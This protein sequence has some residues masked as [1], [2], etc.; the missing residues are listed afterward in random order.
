MNA[1]A[2]AWANAY[3]ANLIPRVDS[4][5]RRDG[6]NAQ[7]RYDVWLQIRM[8]ELRLL[9]APELCLNLLLGAKVE[10][11]V[12]NKLTVTYK[13]PQLERSGV[14]DLSGLAGVCA[15]DAVEVCP[16]VY[17]RGLVTV[18]VPRY[19]GETLSYRLEPISEYDANGF[20]MDAPVIGEAYRPHAD[21]AAVI[22][23]KRLDR[24]AFG[25]LPADEIQRAKDKNAQPFAHL[26]DG[27]GIDSLEHLKAIQAPTWLPRK[28]EAIDVKLPKTE[29]PPRSS[30]AA[31]CTRKATPS[32][33][34]RACRSTRR[35]S[36]TSTRR[37]ACARSWARRGR[38]RCSH[39][40]RS[41]TRRACPRRSSPLRRSDS[42]AGKSRLRADT[43]AR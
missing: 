39:C 26:N 23:A 27:R 30:C 43:C 25:D 20:R 24:T 11:K 29:A 40:W 17:G 8:E 35:R 3:N 15:G 7:T 1:A 33:C 5:L 42:R 21:T 37:C 38:R 34:P 16:M 4:R 2:F 36:A 31:I 22:A 9:P 19:D 18:R 12:S 14:Y 10:R 6:V 32:T 13:H 41:C 28:G